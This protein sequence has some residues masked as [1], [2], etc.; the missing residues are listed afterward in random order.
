MGGMDQPA[1]PPPSALPPRGARIL[2]FM[3]V[4]MG[5]LC[6]GLIGYGV[7]DVSCDGNCQVTAAAVGVLA[8]LFGAAGLAVVAVLTLRAMGEW[9]TGGGRR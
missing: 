5:G 4:L 3:A 8:A 6:G 2:A 1:T 9:K 7:V